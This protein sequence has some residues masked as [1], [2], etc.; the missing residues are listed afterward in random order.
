[1]AGKRQNIRTVLIARFSALGDVAMTVPVIFSVCRCYPDIHFVLVTRQSMTGIFVN[2][3]ANLELVGVDVKNKY[4]GIR[5]LHQLVSDLC[6][7]HQ[8]DAFVDL[9]NV[10]RTRIIGIFCRLRGIKTYHLNKA[11]SRRRALTR[12]NNKVML[13]LVSQ[14]ARYR[15]V[16][17]SAGLPLTEKFNGLFDGHAVAPVDKFAAITQPKPDNIDWIGIAPFSAH[18]G[19]IY[20]PELME[21][22]V[23]HLAERDNTRIFLFGAGDSESAILNEWA[24]KYPAITSLA[25]KKYGFEAELSLFNHLDVV[26]TM[27]SANLHLASIAGTQTISIWGATHPYCGFKGWRQSDND[28]VQLPLTCRPCSVFGNKPCYRGDYLCV[29]GIRPDVIYNKVIEKLSKTHKVNINE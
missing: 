1:M 15:E 17:F 29:S 7:K 22:V 18:R 20:P 5:G 8:F 3:P 19:K 4:A 28:M 6:E 2:S 27:D 23:K 10:L 24:D 9:H 12:R 25:G 26:I 16:F 14:R 21:Q 13:P 11:R